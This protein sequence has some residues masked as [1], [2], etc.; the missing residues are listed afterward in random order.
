M[1]ELAGIGVQANFIYGDPAE[2]E[3]TVAKTIGFYKKNCLDHIVH[4]DYIMPY[5]EVQFLM[6]QRK[7]FDLVQPTILQTLH[8]RPRYNI[9]EMMSKVP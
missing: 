2:T 1:T 9:T 7:R 6:L 8:L 4:N 5:P 3:E